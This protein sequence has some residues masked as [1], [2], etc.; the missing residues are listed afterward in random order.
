MILEDPQLAPFGLEATWY[1]IPNAELELKMS[2]VLEERP[3]ASTTPTEPG[4]AIPP[5]DLLLDPRRRLWAQPLNPRLTNQFGFSLQ[6]AS[7]VKLTIAA[8]PPAAAAATPAQKSVDDVRTLAAPH[9]VKGPDGEPAPR[10]TVNYFGG[11]WYVV[12]TDE[13][14]T[15]PLLTTLLKFDDA[16]GALLHKIGGA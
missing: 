16:S 13:T 9:L 11:A 14:K 15:P 1:Q 7:T 5:K 4:K 12:Q 8:V 10:V 6:A 2:L 3:K